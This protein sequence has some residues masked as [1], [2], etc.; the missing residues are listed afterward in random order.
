MVV[1]FEKISKSGVFFIWFF[2]LLLRIYISVSLDFVDDP[3]FFYE[4]E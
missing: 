3:W 1:A 4:G 2:I